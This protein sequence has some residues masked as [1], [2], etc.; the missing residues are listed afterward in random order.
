MT[1]DQLNLTGRIAGAPCSW[2]VNEVPGWGYQL[3]VD[4]V[5]SEMRGL[6]LAATEFGPDGFLPDRPADKV[7]LLAESA[8][9]A[10]GAFVPV[11]LHEPGHDPVPTAAR[12]IEGLV[13]AGADTLVLAAATGR[14]GYDSRPELDGAGW[15]TLF[16]NVDR[17]RT[18]AAQAGLTACLHPHVGTLIET[19]DDVT[20]LLDGATIPLCLDTGHLLVGGSDPVELAEQAPG[21]VAHV[22]LKDVDAGLAAQVRAGSRTYTD[23]VGAGMYRPLG[24]GDVDVA[25]IVSAL[26][27]AG[28][29]GWYVLEQ[30]AKLR[31]EPP[32]GGGPVLDVRTSLD[33][34]TSLTA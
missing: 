10:V 24:S 30:D 3:T 25:A 20:R 22:H 16:G 29:R 34:L 31:A 7:A 11:V 8:L 6:G 23:A 1:A 12:A 28:Y 18:L 27:R 4:R 21:R 26:E 13:A 33:F 5:L 2:G 9:H 19:R 32:A 14:D 15:Q 17:L